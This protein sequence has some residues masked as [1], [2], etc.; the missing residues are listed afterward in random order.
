MTAVFYYLPKT[1]KTAQELLEYLQTYHYIRCY[2]PEM[3]VEELDRTDKW[4]IYPFR[5]R[6]IV[7]KADLCILADMLTIGN[8][9]DHMQVHK[10][11]TYPTRISYNDLYSNLY[12]LLEKRYYTKDYAHLV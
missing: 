4:H 7:T 2:S 10:T 8:A 11:N 5:K 1:N 6:E 3:V 9:L 12:Q